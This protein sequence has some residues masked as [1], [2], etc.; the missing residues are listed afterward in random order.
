MTNVHKQTGDVQIDQSRVHPSHIKDGKW[1]LEKSQAEVSNVEENYIKKKYKIYSV[2]QIV[3]KHTVHPKIPA[4][5][6]KG[7]DHVQKSHT[8]YD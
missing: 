1:Y 3:H 8:L 5:N 4:Q 7:K 2:R 6:K